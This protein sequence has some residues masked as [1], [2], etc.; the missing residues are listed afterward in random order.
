MCFFFSFGKVL[1]A[2]FA[3]LALV[4]AAWN[5]NANLSLNYAGE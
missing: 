3:F 5:V 2:N 1:L 4:F